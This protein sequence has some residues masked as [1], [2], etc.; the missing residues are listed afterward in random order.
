MKSF[1]ALSQEVIMA[2]RKLIKERNP[3]GEVDNK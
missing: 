3:E 2:A 1:D